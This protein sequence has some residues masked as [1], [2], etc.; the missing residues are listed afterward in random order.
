MFKNQL[1]ALLL[2][3]APLTFVIAACGSILGVDFGAAHLEQDGA[4]DPNEDGGGSMADGMSGP[5]GTTE[6][7]KAACVP[8][9]CAE[10]GFQCGTQKNGCGDALQ[11]GTCEAGICTNGKCACVP[12]TCPDLKAQCGK[13]D[14]GCGGILDCGTC[15]NASD[16][17]DAVTNACEC[18]PKDCAAQGAQCGTVPDGCTGT[19]ACG[20]CSGSPAGPNCSAGKCGPVPCTPKTCASLG[21]N[22][23]QVSDGC[24]G[25]LQCGTCTGTQTCGGAGVTSVCGCTPKTCAQLGQNCGSPADGCG[26]T[27]QCGSC[28][29]PQT[30]GGSGTVDVCGCTPTGMCPGGSNCGTVPN[31]CGGNIA[32]GPTCVSPQTCGG[33]GV[34]LQCGCTPLTCDDYDCGNNLPNGCGGRLNCGIC[35][36][37]GG[38]FAEETPILMADGSMR[39]IS[40]LKRGDMIMGYDEKTG[41]TIARP[42]A[43]LVIHSAEA[44]AD[45]I[46]LINGEIRAT[47]NHPILS[48][49]QR[50]RAEDLKV[51]ASLHVAA[52]A[53][54]GR[55][56]VHEEHVQTVS[57]VS[58]GI[59]SY[60]VKTTPP[61][62]YI[63]G[64]GR[65]VALEKE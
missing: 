32:C 34:A 52:E 3:F 57:F 35:N 21:K 65:V 29:A 1:A 5:T 13:L 11:C 44:S 6:G 39:A 33:G 18:K 19:Y 58:G 36:P 42:V 61:G 38:C 14:N 60:D 64:K 27:L 24:G 22:C 9:T 45:G 31:N 23:G 49:G 10:Q 55:F 40:T 30:C 37:G 25:L 48:G 12:K 56:A 7:G 15:T 43:R 54:G 41:E 62:G 53:R 2:I 63:V 51:G 59:L 8:Q 16:E 17:C 20:D 28:I 46:V 26:G 50:V 4:V 47:R